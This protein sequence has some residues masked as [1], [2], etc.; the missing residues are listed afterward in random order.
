MSVVP[1][2]PL[3]PPNNCSGKVGV[4]HQGREKKHL[5][6]SYYLWRLV[7]IISLTVTGGWFSVIPILQMKEDS[8][9]IQKICWGS[10]L[11]SSLRGLSKVGGVLFLF[12][13]YTSLHT[14]SFK[15]RHPQKS[16]GLLTSTRQSPRAPAL[17]RSGAA[18]K[19]AVLSSSD[20][21]EPAYDQLLGGVPTQS[22][23]ITFTLPFLPPSFPPSWENQFTTCW[24]LGTKLG[25]ALGILFQ[26]SLGNM[27]GVLWPCFV[28]QWTRENL[29]L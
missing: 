22:P 25:L 14:F 20:S 3:L 10:H 28:I 21:Q 2:L 11:G 4:S 5:L 16:L 18:S 8:E 9:V 1:F 7:H 24:V 27:V 17:A 23:E 13:A 15:F 26:S 6:S 12:H 29:W 19:K